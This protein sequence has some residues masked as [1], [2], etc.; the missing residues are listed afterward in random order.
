MLNHRQSSSPRR[1]SRGVTIVIT[2]LFLVLIGTL[3]LG[4][5][6]ST[7]TSMQLAKNDQKGTRALLAAESGVQFMRYHLSHVTVTSANDPNQMMS[8][9]YADLNTALG[10]SGNLGSNTIGFTQ[11]NGVSTITIPQQQ[12]KCIVIDP[13]DNSGFAVTITNVGGGAASIVCKV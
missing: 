12:G 6:A 7:T 13:T 4:F 8:D 3:S 10:A 9:L 5:Y 2:M 11:S 1:R